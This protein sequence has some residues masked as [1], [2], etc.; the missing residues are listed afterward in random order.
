MASRRPWATGDFGGGVEAG[1]DHGDGRVASTGKVEASS[2]LIE[3]DGHGV[4][5]A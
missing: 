3:A 4:W 5:A 1:I 2:E